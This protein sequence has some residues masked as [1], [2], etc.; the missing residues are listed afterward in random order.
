MDLEASVNSEVPDF[1]GS[2]SSCEENAVTLQLIHTKNPKVAEELTQ[3]VTALKRRQL[4]GSFNVALATCKLYRSILSSVFFETIQPYVVLVRRVGRMLLSAQPLEVVSGCMARRVLRI[5]REY[6]KTVVSASKDVIPAEDLADAAAHYTA[7]V[8]SKAKAEAE[9][10]DHTNFSV[11][12]NLLNKFL[13]PD[14]TTYL[15]AVQYRPIR[16]SI[17][18]D[19]NTELVVYTQKD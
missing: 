15:S 5:M 14:P 3:I 10:T 17:L 11:H 8:K 6:A 16:S 7:V 13:S 18:D 1:S 12:G 19:I 9:N 2:Q 4:V